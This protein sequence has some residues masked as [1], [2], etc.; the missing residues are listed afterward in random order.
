MS[1]LFSRAVYGVSTVLQGSST[2]HIQWEHFFVVGFFASVFFCIQ[3]VLS[4]QPTK[5]AGT[6]QY[7]AKN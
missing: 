6:P 1:E 4:Q 5:Q 7:R 3:G 2:G